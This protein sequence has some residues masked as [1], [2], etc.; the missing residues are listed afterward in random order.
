[1]R[2]AFSERP[3]NFVILSVCFITRKKSSTC[4]RRL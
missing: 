2:T 1:M 4:Q 3:M